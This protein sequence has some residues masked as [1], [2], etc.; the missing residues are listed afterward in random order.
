MPFLFLVLADRMDLNVRAASAP[1]HVLVKYTDD[2]GRT[3]NL[4]ATSG[5]GKTRDLWYRKQLTISDRAV[6]SGVNLQPLERQQTIVLMASI[7]VE[8]LLNQ[9]EYVDAI[10]VSDMLLHYYPKSVYLMVKKGTAYYHLIR[11]EFYEKYPV[12]SD[13]PDHLHARYKQLNASNQSA[14]AKAEALGW[15]P[16]EQ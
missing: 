9:G 5:A 8:H 16:Q 6:A 4:E 3:W 2:H 14:F 13:V 15:M 1:L 12:A 10:V 11:T 7:L